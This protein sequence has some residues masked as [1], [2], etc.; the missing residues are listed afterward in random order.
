MKDKLTELAN[1]YKNNNIDACFNILSS[2]VESYNYKL[3]EDG[4]YNHDL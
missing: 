2:I 4:C 3:N 1:N